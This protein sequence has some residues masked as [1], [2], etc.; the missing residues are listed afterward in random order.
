MR[1]RTV[2]SIGALLVTVGTVS[3]LYGYLTTRI[4]TH[5]AFVTLLGTIIFRR[6]RTL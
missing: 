1:R 3:A 2:T 5:G 4:V 6:L